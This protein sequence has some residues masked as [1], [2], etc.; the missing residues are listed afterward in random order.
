MRSERERMIF[1]ILLVGDYLSE[2]WVQSL[3]ASFGVTAE[4]LTKTKVKGTRCEMEGMIADL[5][6]RK[7]PLQAMRGI[8]LTTRGPP[9]GRQNKVLLY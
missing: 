6:P 2:Q 9:R 3:K 7:C 4:H 5:L 1:G 8:A